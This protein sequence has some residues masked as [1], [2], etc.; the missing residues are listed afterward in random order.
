M[1]SYNIEEKTSC[2]CV[3]PLLICTTCIVCVTYVTHTPSE[4]IILGSIRYCDF[5]FPLHMLRTVYKKHY[6]NLHVKSEVW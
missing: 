1:L 5:S 4:Y 2:G 6:L 3:H